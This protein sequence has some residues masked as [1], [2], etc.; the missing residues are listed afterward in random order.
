MLSRSCRNVYPRLGTRCLA[1]RWVLWLFGSCRLDKARAVS[2]VTQ[3]RLLPLGTNRQSSCFRTSASVVAGKGDNPIHIPSSRG[4][5]RL[6]IP[7]PNPFSSRRWQC[8]PSS[9]IPRLSGY[10]TTMI[11]PATASK[12]QQTLLSLVARSLCASIAYNVQCVRL[13]RQLRIPQSIY[14]PRDTTRS[15]SRA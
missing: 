12:R 13:H 4:S 3:R 8:L 5:C 11:N 2:P 6:G 1:C 15:R 10:S 14:C 9:A 7:N